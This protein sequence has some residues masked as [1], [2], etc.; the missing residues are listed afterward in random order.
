MS[1]I[2]GSMGLIYFVHEWQPK[3]DEAALLHDPEMLRAVTAINRQITELAPVLNSPTVGDAVQVSS[4]DPQVPVAAMLK[5]H[6]G[7]SYLFAVAM[8]NGNTTATFTLK[9]L[10]G[11]K[12]VEVLGEERSLSAR[13]GTFSDSFKSWAVHGYRI[14]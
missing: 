6:A 7:A 13:N 2:H 12:T 4:S 11:E 14:K 3:F 1:L 5:R 9:G 8:R 10:A